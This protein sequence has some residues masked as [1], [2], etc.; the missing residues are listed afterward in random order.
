MSLYANYISIAMWPI[1]SALRGTDVH[2][3]GWEMGVVPGNIILGIRAVRLHE[4]S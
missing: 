2:W 1:V 3:V 4:F